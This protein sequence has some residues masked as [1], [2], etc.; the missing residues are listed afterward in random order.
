MNELTLIFHMVLSLW[1]LWKPKPR[2][3]F[4]EVLP[5]GNSGRW[6]P[7]EKKESKI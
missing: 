4:L 1:P 6:D 5:M 2:L 7:G 3:H